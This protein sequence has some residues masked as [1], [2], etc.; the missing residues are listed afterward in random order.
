MWV[1]DKDSLKASQEQNEVETIFERVG[2]V[3]SNFTNSSSE[4]QFYNI[5]RLEADIERVIKAGL[6]ILNVCSEPMRAD[7]LSS[8]LTGNSFV[9][10]AAPL[11][12]EEVRSIHANVFGHTGPYLFG[13]AT[14]LSDLK[15]FFEAELRA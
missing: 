5:Q 1:L 10:D 4:F 7:Y 14:V 11:V 6:P 9:N 3:S 13:K 15:V 8:E 12:R 2:F